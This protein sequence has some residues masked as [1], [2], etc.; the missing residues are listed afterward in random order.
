MPPQKNISE[1]LSSELLLHAYT[2]GVFPMA[3]GNEGEIL[4]YSPEPRAII[5]LDAFNISRS[6]RRTLKKFIFDIRI[7]T[8]FENVIRCCAK[9]D[10]TWISEEI[11]SAYCELHRLGYAHSVETWNKENLVGGLYGVAIGAAFFG[12][13]M[14]SSMTDASKVAL[15][16]LVQ[17]MNEH[18]FVLLDTQYLTSHL[19]QFGATEIPRKDY[20]RLL[21]KAISEKNV[22]F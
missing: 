12:E 15:V 20:L 21:K 6:L 14:F 19:K 2:I 22:T 13:S 8:S 5:P 10:D 1:I 4:W 9:R 16:S 17:R 3:N 7:D 18:G 11:I